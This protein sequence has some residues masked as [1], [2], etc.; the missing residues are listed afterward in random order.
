MSSQAEELKFGVAIECDVMVPMRD[1]VRLA[2]DIHR[3]ARDGQALAG[4]FPV[5]LER[6]PYDKTGAPLSERSAADPTPMNRARVAEHF[7][8][9]GYIVVYQDCRGRHGSQGRFTKYLGE[10]E[11]GYDTMA[12]LIQQP[13]CNGKIGTMGLSYAAHAQMAL[14]CLKAPGLSAMLLDSGGFASAY[15]AGIRQGGAFELKQATWAYKHAQLSG[16][17]ARDPVIAAALERE[18]IKAW[19]TAMPWRPGH[20]PLKWTPDY[21]AYLLDQWCRGSFD[22]YWRQIGLYAAGHYAAMAGIPVMLLC[23]WWDPYVQTTVDNYLGLKDGARGKVHM[24]MGPWT[25]GQRSVTFAGDVDFGA[26]ATLD[27]AIAENHLEFRRTWF[28]RWLKDGAAQGH[29]AP[30]VRYFRM[31]GGGGGRTAAGR[32]DHGGSWIEAEAW[33]PASAEALPLHL[34]ADGGFSETPP[35]RDEDYLSFDYDP[36]DPVPTI[37]GTVTSGAPVMEGGAY[38]QVEDV[39]FFG[40]KAPYLPL[41]A[42]HDV[43]VF[44]S[45]PLENDLDVTG[46]I[47]AKL[48]VSST[49]RDT[50]FTIKL[51]DVHPPSADYPCGFAMN[52]TDGILRCRYR[53]SWESP[54]LMEPGEV[55][56]ITVEA[57]ATSNLFKR[58]HRIRLDISSSNFP[59]FDV[60]T[61]TGEP[62]GTARRIEV[63][64]NTV[65][66]DR[67]RPSHLLLPVVGKARP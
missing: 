44:Q 33:P 23:G 36:R 59:H 19:F 28:D 54:R 48:W 16:V 17:A 51:I 13:W 58:G 40:S 1:G 49:C 42:R 57:F 30:A 62:E 27:G 41:A 46:T 38:D 60:N 9:H 4:R 43:L 6:T 45:P 56:Q 2:T 53:D 65:Y 50:D 26:A 8:A 5:L 47:F 11:D 61:N 39:R 37:G 7:A 15:R 35:E 20:S 55:Y 32:L 63:A 14:A 22:A 3:P 24:V 67:A 29:G 21:E 66:M 64:T 34:C 31:G 18:D 10:G 52:L 12:W 25:H